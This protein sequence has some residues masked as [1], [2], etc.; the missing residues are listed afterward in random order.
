M[1]QEELHVS[2]VRLF[3]ASL[4][5]SKTEKQN[6]G[7]FLA[8]LHWPSVETSSQLAN[9]GAADSSRA[10]TGCKGKSSCLDMCS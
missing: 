9:E 3:P 7:L 10:V 6:C 8:L 4:R 1:Q 2:I 5:A